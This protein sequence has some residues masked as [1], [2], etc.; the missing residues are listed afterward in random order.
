[1]CHLPW[2]KPKI[3]MLEWKH[4]WNRKKGWQYGKEHLDNIRRISESIQIQVAEHKTWR[5]SVAVVN[6]SSKVLWRKLFLKAVEGKWNMVPSDL[7]RWCGWW[8]GYSGICFTELNE[9]SLKRHKTGSVFS[10]R[11]LFLCFCSGGLSS[12]SDGLFLIC[13]H[14][15]RRTSC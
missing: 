14:Y 6:S 11:Y 10:F 4:V 3:V 12:V 15:R 2:K 5:E 7:M 1:M 8:D 9:G 13:L